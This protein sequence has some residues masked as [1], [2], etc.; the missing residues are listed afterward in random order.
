MK[1]F[2]RD[3]FESCSNSMNTF[4]NNIFPGGLHPQQQ[5][6]IDGVINIFCSETHRYYHTLNQH[7]FPML[8]R[9]LSGF[10]THYHDKCLS[11]HFKKYYFWAT[12]YHDIVYDPRNANGENEKLSMI[13]WEEDAE[14][15]GVNINTK[16][17]VS[18]LILATATHTATNNLEKAFLAMDLSG[19]TQPFD[20][21]LRDELLI[22]KEYDFVD[23]AVYQKG[24]IDFLKKYV[25]TPI[26][27]SM[28]M[29][30]VNNLEKQSEYMRFVEPKIAIYPGSFNPLHTGHLEIFKKAE[31]IFDKVIWVFASN[32][33]KDAAEKQIPKALQY[34]QVE[35]VSGSLVTW[36]KSL[37]YPVTIIRGIRD[38]DDFK[39]EQNY[40]SW[41][42]E[43]NGAEL[44][45]V[46][47]FSDAEHS[48]IS[49][50]AIRALNK[51]HPEVSEKFIVK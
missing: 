9:Y 19:F 15:L 27:K 11:P 18:E 44:Q 22:R 28:G 8:G 40:L 33:D 32:L 29:G 4:I 51:I 16:K 45:S 41:L 14:S 48:K 34:N 37:P 12:L 46:N 2:V 35:I 30:V 5:K 13:K 20:F 25:E 23:W 49:S 43:I 47:I 42:E 7:I 36:I 24:R 10:F 31:K 26:I 1:Y 21:I 3:E 38:G 17:T 6:M 50:S 39:A